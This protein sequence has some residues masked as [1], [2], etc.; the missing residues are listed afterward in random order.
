MQISFDL[1]KRTDKKFSNDTRH[2][3]ETKNELYLVE[4]VGADDV[5]TDDVKI[6]IL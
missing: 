4:Y 1:D 5:N 3:S 2:F 6:P